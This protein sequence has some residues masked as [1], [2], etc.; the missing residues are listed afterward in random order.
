MT[1]STTS[2]MV[3]MNPRS[4]LPGINEPLA[5]V[6]PNQYRRGFSLVMIK[7]KMKTAKVASRRMMGK[8]PRTGTPRETE[9]MATKTC[10]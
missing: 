3:G 1:N 9:R 10:W 6:S 4:L 8:D 2:T 5:G 7:D